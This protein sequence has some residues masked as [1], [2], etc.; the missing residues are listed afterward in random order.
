MKL[1]RI[2]L[3]GLRHSEVEA[4]LAD[5]FFWRNIKEATVITGNSVKMK[6]IVIDWLKKHD[7]NYVIEAHN[8]GCINV[9]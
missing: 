7:Y 6:E 2:D 1:A 5:A 8:L 4:A 9:L 3:H